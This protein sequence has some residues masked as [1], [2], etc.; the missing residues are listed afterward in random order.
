MT[1]KNRILLL[2]NYRT[3]SSD[4][5]FKLSKDNEAKCFPEPHL[6]EEE[7]NL[8]EKLFVNNEP[9][10]VKFMPDQIDKHL[11]YQEILNSDCY[12]IKLTRENKIEQIASYYV[13]EMTT[14]WNSKN[15]LARGEKYTVKFLADSVRKSI[16][17]INKNDKLINDLAIK[18]DEELTYEYLLNN[19]L[20]GSH[21]AKIIE[22]VNIY[23][24]KKYIERIYNTPNT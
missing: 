6:Y 22:P 17:I 9:F 10:V 12:K 4:Y 7:Y 11:L 19:N 21:N 18:F 14:I 5:T 2:A 1:T 3:G 8:L 20:L 23:N 13:A 15:S 24:I 16:D